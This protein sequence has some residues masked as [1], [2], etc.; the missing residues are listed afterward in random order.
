MGSTYTVPPLPLTVTQADLFDFSLHSERNMPASS[1]LAI[2]SNS[3]SSPGSILPTVLLSAMAKPSVMEMPF[4]HV[5]FWRK[6]PLNSSALIKPSLSTSMRLKIAK[7]RSS[8]KASSSWPILSGK[9]LRYF[10]NLS[11][12]IFL[13]PPASLNSSASSRSLSCMCSESAPARTF[14]LAMTRY[15]SPPSSSNGAHASVA[16]LI[17]SSSVAHFSVASLT[18]RFIRKRCSC[19]PAAFLALVIS[20]WTTTR[21]ACSFFTTSACSALSFEARW[22]SLTKF[23]TSAIFAFAAF[24]TAKRFSKGSAASSSDNVSASS[25]KKGS[26]ASK[27][28]FASASASST[29]TPASWIWAA[30]LRFSVDLRNA[31]SFV[32]AAVMRSIISANTSATGFALSSPKAFATLLLAVT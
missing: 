9:S 3:T 22:R 32:E 15:V 17:S 5:H 26:A 14:M 16:F 11:C 21:R 24:S 18:K 23:L 1:T 30:F 4:L 12:L 31:V 10:R 27:V 19:S 29:F 13:P 2:P 7:R 8:V 6:R 20:P 25:F 28:F